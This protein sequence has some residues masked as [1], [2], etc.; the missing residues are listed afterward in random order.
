MSR[1]SKRI[2]YLHVQRNTAEFTVYVKSTLQLKEIPV[3]DDHLN[4]R[5][6]HFVL[7][8]RVIKE[9]DFGQFDGQIVFGSVRLKIKTQFVI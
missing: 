8:D 6:L 7:E 3:F 1:A 2:K 9:D 4:A 5:V